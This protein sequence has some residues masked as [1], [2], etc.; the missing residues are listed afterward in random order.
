MLRHWRPI[1]GIAVWLA[2]LAALTWLLISSASPPIIAAH[3]P[4][5]GANYGEPGANLFDKF[6][7]SLVLFFGWIA[8][9]K[10]DVWSAIA[11][12]VIA[13]F[14]GF[15]WWSTR[16]L[17][18]QH[19]IDFE[20]LERAYIFAGPGELRWATP[21]GYET[22]SP[23]VSVR[24]TVGNFGRTFGTIKECF[25]DFLS[26][27]PT[28]EYPSYPRTGVISDDLVIMP[29]EKDKIL[30]PRFT[31]NQTSLP[32]FVFGYVAYQDVIRRKHTSRFCVCMENGQ[33]TPVGSRHWNEWD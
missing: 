21:Q 19:E 15:L 32:L 16:A 17:W 24:I 4:N 30:N 11:T 7:T 31:T 12:I 33:V 2:I 29:G 6:Q 3:Q 10:S 1:V 25:L 14:T 28:A 20:R 26:E 23:S 22:V 18:R 8:G 9:W 13:S 5:N 27:E